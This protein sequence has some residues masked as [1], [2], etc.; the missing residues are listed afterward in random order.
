MS[1]QEKQPVT[2]GLALNAV[3]SEFRNWLGQLWHS[4]LSVGP[5]DGMDFAPPV[6]MREERDSY[7][8]QVEVPGVP[9]SQI[10]VTGTQATLRI[11]GQKLS[12]ELRT[13][14]DQPPSRVLQSQRRYGSFSRMIN[15]PGPININN[16]SAHLANG[17]LEVIAPKIAE[18]TAINVQVHVQSGQEEQG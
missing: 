18:T 15:L 13:A 14:E 5:M 3:Q 16:V 8:I 7:R 10:E 6:E 12:P 1:D 11:S 9:L 17:V 4:G 2:V